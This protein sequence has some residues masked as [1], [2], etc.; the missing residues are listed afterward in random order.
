[1]KKPA[2]A[3]FHVRILIAK[4]CQLKSFEESS[5]TQLKSEVTLL[6]GE[7]IADAVPSSR[8]MFGVSPPNIPRSLART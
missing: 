4:Q 1:M 2:P 6:F 3:M 7:S 5:H 8:W